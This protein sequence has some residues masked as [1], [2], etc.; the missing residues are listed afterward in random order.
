VKCCECVDVG[1]WWCVFALLSTTGFVVCFSPSR[2]SNALFRTCNSPMFEFCL[3]RIGCAVTFATIT[4]SVIASVNPYAVLKFCFRLSFVRFG[5]INPPFPINPHHSSSAI[6]LIGT[7]MVLKQCL[8]Y[9]STKL[10]FANVDL[11]MISMLFSFSLEFVF[12]VIVMVFPCHD[13][14]VFHL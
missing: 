2:I 6:F 4:L 9:L 14:S 8:R 3:I 11:C 1:V 10:V 13:N 12:G 5:V 7:R